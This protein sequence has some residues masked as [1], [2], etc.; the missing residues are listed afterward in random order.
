M[1]NG[2]GD[3]P[4]PVNWDKYLDNYQ[5]INWRKVKPRII[6][7]ET[8]EAYGM[9]VAMPSASSPAPRNLVDEQPK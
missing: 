5:A 1:S 3:S 7:R 9:P 8:L 2:K 6:P 4:R